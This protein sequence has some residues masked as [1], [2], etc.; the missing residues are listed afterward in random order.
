MQKLI[1][2]NDVLLLLK[3]KK[4]GDIQ[5]KQNLAFARKL[6]FKENSC[7][8]CISYQNAVTQTKQNPFQK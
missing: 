4:T 5:T 1:S 6:T 2:I 7:Q 8:H 3:W